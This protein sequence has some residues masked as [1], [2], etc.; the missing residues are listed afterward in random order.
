MFS[1][2]FFFWHSGSSY[3]NPIQF[4]NILFELL[5][6]EMDSFGQCAAAKH[7]GNISYLLPLSIPMSLIIWQ[8]GWVSSSYSSWSPA[9]FQSVIVSLEEALPFPQKDALHRVSLGV[10]IWDW[11]HFVSACFLTA[12]RLPDYQVIQSVVC[13]CPVCTSFAVSSICTSLST[14]RKVTNL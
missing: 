6:P 3:L 9:L 12:T 4:F 2:F 1:F 14:F 11:L 5:T 13:H 7:E 10:W 8:K